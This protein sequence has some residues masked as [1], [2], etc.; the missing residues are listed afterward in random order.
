M[1]EKMVW[2]P[3]SGVSGTVGEKVKPFS[4]PIESFRISVITLGVFDM[5]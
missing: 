1:W 4:G 2:D 3:E 5:C